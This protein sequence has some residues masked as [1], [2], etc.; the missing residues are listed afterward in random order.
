MSITVTFTNPRQNYDG[1]GGKSEA[2]ALSALEPVFQFD[3]VSQ[4]KMEVRHDVTTKYSLE[5]S[6]TLNALQKNSTFIITDDNGATVF[7][8]VVTDKPT[9]T[10]VVSN[11][12]N[13]ATYLV[14]NGKGVEGALLDTVIPDASGNETWTRST[15][16]FKVGASGAMPLQ[17]SSAYG[18]FQSDT[19][20]PDPADAEGAKCYIKDASCATDTIAANILNTDVPPFYIEFTT[21]DKGMTPQ[22][23]LKINA[24]WFYREGYDATGGGDKFR[25]QVIARAELGT[26][27]AN[28]TAGDDAYDKTAKR[29]GP[30]TPIVYRDDGGGDVKLRFQKEYQ[31][32]YGYGC[33]VLTSPASTDTFSGTYYVYDSDASLDATSTILYLEDLIMAMV[34][35]PAAYGGAGFSSVQCDFDVTGVGITRYDY[36]P[37]DRSPIAWNAINE[38]IAMLNL[39]DEIKFWYKHS[40]GK[41]RLAQLSNG[42]TDHTITGGI[43]RMESDES[44]ADLCSAVRLAY[45]SDQDPNLVQ[46][47]YSY[48][49]APAAAGA[50]PDEYRRYTVGIGGGDWGGTYTSYATGDPADTDFG[51]DMLVDGKNDT[52]RMAY[53]EHD[54]G[55]AFDAGHFWFDAGAQVIKLD[56]LELWV[57]SYRAIEGWSRTTHNDNYEYEVRVEGCADYDTTINAPTS[58]EWLDLGGAIIG[59]PAPDGIAVKLEMDAPFLLPAVNAIRIVFDYMAGPKISG[60][61]YWAC[62][63]QLIV[64][65]NITKYALV[66]TTDN[67]ALKT[68]PAYV[69]N[70]AAHK[71]LRGGINSSGAAGVPI[72]KI[73]DNIG[74]ASEGAAYTIARAHLNGAL[75]LYKQRQYATAKALATWP[76]L[77]DTIATDGEYTGVCRMFKAALRGRQRDY[78]YRVLDYDAA[79]VDS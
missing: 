16:T 7:R 6:H 30:Q 5:T 1:A 36:N 59:T 19:L 54:P 39:S 56:Y 71:K 44:M 32:M 67:A 50:V 24:E 2:I 70:V 23:W 26:A 15:S 37:E 38:L 48:I 35:A 43:Y 60:D 62:I 20:W 42:V 75:H 4:I 76:E 72:V 69:Y 10:V 46:Q 27:A 25:T 21:A 57:N 13:T 41:F 3:V 55:G 9:H 73:V 40:T 51:T 17:P 61:F 18:T 79:S 14:V 58:G 78:Q 8:G 33:F 68:N 64:R 77:G 47:Q 49:Q 65:G 34:T 45:T 12:G 22:G 29:I 74:P 53:F 63:H 52:L 66:Q 28:H 11:E 31:V